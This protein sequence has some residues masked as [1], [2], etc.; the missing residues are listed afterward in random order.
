MSAKTIA[1]SEKSKVITSANVCST[2]VS[3]ERLLELCTEARVG[4][5]LAKLR[6]LTDTM[7]FS[8]INWQIYQFKF[9]ITLKIF[10]STFE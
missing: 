8:L 1:K 6:V 5:F 3:K 2:S 4:K 10:L 7:M 9:A